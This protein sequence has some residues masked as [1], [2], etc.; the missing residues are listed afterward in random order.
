MNKLFLFLFFTTII[1]GNIS[2]QTYP[3]DFIIPLSGQTVHN[4]LY[5][6]IG[7]IDSRPTDGLINRKPKRV[8]AIPISNQLNNLMDSLTD[9]TAKDGALLLQLRLLNFAEVTGTINQKGT[10][11]LRAILY[12]KKGDR[13]QK[14]NSIDT[15]VGIQVSPNLSKGALANGGKIISAFITDNLLQESTDSISYSLNDIKKI[16]SVEKSQLKLY[17]TLTYT[18]G[19][20][21][22]YESFKNQV[23]DKQIIK[24]D[25][26]MNGNVFAV[27]IIDNGQKIK[28]KPKEM[29]AVVYKGVPYMATKYG[30]YKMQ[31][32]DGNFFFTGDLEIKSDIGDSVAN[33]AAYGLLGVVA[34]LGEETTF[35][36]RL[37]H[38]NG[39][40]IRLK[41]VEAPTP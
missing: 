23:P 13:Y 34:S 22:S 7:F 16:D 12:S 20:Y 37:D 36:M 27:K 26:N 3:E 5:K 38:A 2:A 21:Y 41:Q 31:K 33:D 19:L 11:Y 40:F 1:T 10:C 8:T 35:D 17:T 9:S 30:C 25:T 39:K 18:E 32:T 24:A 14:I 28:I 6:T 4:S 15:S 29:Y